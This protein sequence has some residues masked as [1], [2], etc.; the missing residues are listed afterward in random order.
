V[1]ATTARRE[2]T[3]GGVR[4]DAVA[5]TSGQT[6]VADLQAVTVTVSCTVPRADLAPLAPGTRTVVATSTE[7][8]DVIRAVDR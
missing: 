3:D 8:I 5:V 7:V 4:C 1:A 2:L 6:I